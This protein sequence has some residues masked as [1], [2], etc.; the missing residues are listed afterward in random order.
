M[1]KRKQYRIENVPAKPSG[2]GFEQ[3]L[4]TRPTFHGKVSIV[5]M[6]KA[7]RHTA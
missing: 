4:K 6:R 3:F 1:F 5:A 2:G 7:R